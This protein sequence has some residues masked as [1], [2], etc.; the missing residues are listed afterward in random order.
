[1]GSEADYADIDP[2]SEVNRTGK[3]FVRLDRAGQV[4]EL[5]LD[6][7]EKLN[8]WAWGPTNELCA[9]ADELRF[10]TSVRVVILRAEGRAFCAGED[11]KPDAHNVKDRHAGRTRSVDKN[12]T[13]TR[14]FATFVK[15]V[16]NQSREDAHTASQQRA[17]Q[18]IENIERARET[19]GS[20]G[21]NEDRASRGAKNVAAGD[22]KNIVH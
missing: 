9:L 22:S 13:I 2:R 15:G 3:P 4:A 6:R 20:D 18:E 10:D 8:A 11:L 14:R 17:E 1:M 19:S 16:L 21:E 12:G 5:V 7:P